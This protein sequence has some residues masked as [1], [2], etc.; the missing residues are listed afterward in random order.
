MK[1][2]IKLNTNPFTIQTLA[3]AETAVAD[4][5]GAML[6]RRELETQRDARLLEVRTDYDHTFK[7]IDARIGPKLAALHEWAGANPAAFKAR[8]SIE[9]AAGTLGF[10][11]GTPRLKALKG[12]T[13]DAVLRSLRAVGL[14]EF[15]RMK[16]E[17]DK[18]AIIAARREIPDETMKKAGLTLVQE[19]T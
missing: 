1:N 12:F 6:Y 5:T 13:W 14:N 15:I 19:E 9:F 3:E 4:L 10:R 17:V 7:E 8:K 11:T 16:E 2:R 18:E